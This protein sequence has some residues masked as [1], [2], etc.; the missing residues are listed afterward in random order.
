VIQ[1][2]L[3]EVELLGSM[4]YNQSLQ[5]AD[6]RHAPVYGADA[7]AINQLKEAMQLLMEHIRRIRR[8]REF[9]VDNV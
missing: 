4:Y 6:L 1:E 9:K 3:K 2:Q 7:A 8:Y 5:E